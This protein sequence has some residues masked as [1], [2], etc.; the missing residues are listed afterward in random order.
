MAKIN[1]TKTLADVREVN[2]KASANYRARNLEETRRLARERMRKKR[3]SKKSP[4]SE[5]DQA[6]V[7]AEPRPPKH[8]I[9]DVQPDETNEPTPSLS[10]SLPLD[11]LQKTHDSV[12]KI[13]VLTERQFSQPAYLKEPQRS[14]Q[15]YP[16]LPS[17]QDIFLF[18]SPTPCGEVHSCGDILGMFGTPLQQPPIMQPHY[19]R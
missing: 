13:P 4:S 15:S 10:L 16:Q 5:V 18:P 9:K 2:K 12:S 8:C 7:P 17:F 6:E 3:Q 11:D 1:T 14:V 19:F